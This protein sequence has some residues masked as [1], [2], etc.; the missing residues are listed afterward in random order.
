MDLNG[1]TAIITGSSGRV[2]SQI[3]MALAE[4]GCNCICHYNKNRQKAEHIV[5]EIRQNGKK[6]VAVDAD[7]T[8]PAQ[9]EN[10]FSRACELGVPRILINSAAVFLRQPLAEATF[11]QAQKVLNLNL[12]APILVSRAFAKIIHD[13]FANTES[14][15]GKIINI[16]DVGGIRP[17]REYVLYC[18]SKAGLIGATKALAKELAPQIT[19]NAVAPGM[20]TWA[21]DFD[22][23]QRKRQLKLIPLGRIGEPKEVAEAIIFL[24]ENDYITGQVLNVDGGR[25]I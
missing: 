4:N 18:S 2:G 23:S 17:W 9:I 19:V 12:V 14:V 21:D 7:L 15:V 20:V 25:C 24:L 1:T 16:S 6:A 3:A 22:E 8:V 5:R 11:E 13:E 10:L